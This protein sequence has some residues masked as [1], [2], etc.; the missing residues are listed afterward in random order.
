M[1]TTISSPA[2]FK[3]VRTAFNAEGY[4]DGVSNSFLAYR[5]GGGIVPTT[6]P[7]N[8]IGAGVGSPQPDKLQLSQFNGF[9]VPNVIATLSNH[10][11][12]AF[13]TVSS[14][15]DAGPSAAA[16]L[17][18]N[19]TPSNSVFNMQGGTGYGSTWSSFGSS[20]LING[21][22]Y[23][24]NTF[25]GSSS[26]QVAVQRWANDDRPQL[27][28]CRATINTG[29]STTPD[30]FI[31]FR[32]GTYGSWLSLASAHQFRVL[33]SAGSA[34]TYNLITLVMTLEFAKTSNLS[35]ILGSCT[36]TLSAAAEFTG[37][38]GGGN[39]PE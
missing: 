18:V 20:I 19:N 31:T 7:F 16:S 37:G 15:S 30:N 36:I 23:W 3:S 22:E 4:G 29:L 21:V 10:T 33:T 28:S 11:T 1:P 6:S 25:A 24:G 35:N 38:G 34:S 13:H 27:Y 17:I 26:G 5:Q 32:E 8:A 2:G 39:V 12:T 9:S 14:P